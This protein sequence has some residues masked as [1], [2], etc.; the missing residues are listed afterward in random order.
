MVTWF[1]MVMMMTVMM[2]DDYGDD[3]DG[4]VEDYQQGRRSLAGNALSDHQVESSLD[5][6]YHHYHG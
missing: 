5:C 1:M 2:I 4:G 3:G 6:G